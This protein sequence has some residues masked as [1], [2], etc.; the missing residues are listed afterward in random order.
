MCVLPKDGAPVNDVNSYRPISLT[1]L[2]VKAMERLVLKRIV[3]KLDD[4][5]QRMQSGFRQKRSTVDNL[6]YLLSAI[7]NRWQHSSNAPFVAAFLDFSK[8]FDRTWHTG[9]LWKCHKFGIDGRAWRW[10]RAFLTG[11]QLRVVNSGYYS[12]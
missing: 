7:E 4:K 1:S 6:N 2:V 8:A 5:L 12:V 3:A 11:R 9:V 10:I